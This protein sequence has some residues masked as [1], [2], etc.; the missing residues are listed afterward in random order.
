ML[1]VTVKVR[2]KGDAG[3]WLAE[4]E[5]RVQGQP[6]GVKVGFPAGSG[7]KGSG[8]VDIVQIAIWNHFGTAGSG[9]NFVRTGVGGTHG[10]FGGPI[11]PR[12]FITVAVW[13]NREKIRAML[14]RLYLDILHGRTTAQL[15]MELLGQ[16]GVDIIKDTMVKGGFAPNSPLTVAIKGS[17]QPLID[18]GDLKNSVTWAFA[19]PGPGT[20]AAGG[21]SRA[22]KTG[23]AAGKA[24]GQAL[25]RMF[26]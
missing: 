24:F 19:G 17:S 16:F 10:G 18:K 12:P 2:R 25:A 3:K 23:R 22:Y 1:K 13:R 5:Q 7:G 6:H 8:L 14:K 20:G 21:K 11:P 9:T 15:G 26:K 4:F